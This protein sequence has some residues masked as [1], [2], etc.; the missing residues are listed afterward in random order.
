M[1]TVQGFGVSIDVPAGWS[2]RMTRPE[3]A[4]VLLHAATF[5]EIDPANDGAF[6]SGAIE[7]VAGGDIFVSLVEYLADEAIVPGQGLYATT[8]MQTDLS[9]RDFNPQTLQLPRS[10]HVGLQQFFSIG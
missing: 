3:S 9:A 2:A 5:P 6:G 4:G 8:A 10:G 1:A 7:H